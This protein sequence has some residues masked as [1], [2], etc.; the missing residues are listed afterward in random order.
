MPRALREPYRPGAAQ[1]T[2]AALGWTFIEQDRLEVGKVRTL[3]RE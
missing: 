1:K 3:T 2:S